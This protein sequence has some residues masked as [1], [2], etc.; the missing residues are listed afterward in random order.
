MSV[1]SSTKYEN[2]KHST[3]SL[4]KRYS[5]GGLYDSAWPGAGFGGA[6]I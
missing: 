6:G 5:G 4:V 2:E 1:F 3:S